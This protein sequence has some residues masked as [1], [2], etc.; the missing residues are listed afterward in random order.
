MAEKKLFGTDG[1]R[2]KANAYPMTSEIALKVG[3]AAGHYFSQDR[4]RRHKVLIG[5]D[6]RLSCYML[7][8]SLEAGLLSMGVDVLEV[9]PLPTPGVA[10]VTRSLRADAGIMISASHNP[11]QDNGIKFFSKDGYK[12]PDEVEHEIERLAFSETLDE[13][14]PTAEDIGAA[15]HIHDGIGRYVEF[16]KQSFP[17][18]VTLDGLRIV[19]DCAN[20]AAYKVAPCVLRELGAEIVP[21][22]IYPSGQNINENCGSQ[23]PEHMLDALRKCGADLGVTFDGDADRVLLADS[24][25][26][27]YDGDKLMGICAAKYAEKGQLAHNTLVSTVMTNVGLERSLARKGIR[28]ERTPV[29]DRY[30]VERMLE[31][32]FNLGGEQSG[33][34]IFL[35]HNTTGDGIISMLQ[36]LAI[37]K[38]SGKSLADLSSWIEEFP[39][40]LTNVT[41]S[42]RPPI[43]EVSALNKSIQAARRE[44]GD[45]G[46][47][48][49]RYSGTEPMIRIMIQGRN[50]D[51]IQAM[52]NDLARIAQQELGD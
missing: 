5:K 4:E 15:F 3:R 10:Y 11:Y 29:G 23:H 42:Q 35:D 16:L 21:I 26:R 39:Q 51:R 44:L 36:V 8:R 37:L 52:A 6:T 13:I 45:E 49:V 20:G 38:Q 31:G 43:E 30:V 34:I 25:G 24:S 2:G 46:I 27:L 50:R 47:I 33:H 14:R 1:I 32:G 41:V 40:V 12:L 28:M 19:A 7:E 18:G 17:K 22:S 9:G 48:L